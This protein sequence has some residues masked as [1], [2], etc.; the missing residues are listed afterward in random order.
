[1]FQVKRQPIAWRMPPIFDWRRRPL[2]GVRG[3][4]ATTGAPSHISIQ[5]PQAT[6]HHTSRPVQV[7]LGNPSAGC[8]TVELPANRV[9]GAT[10]DGYV[11]SHAARG[12]VVLSRP[13]RCC[14]FGAVMRRLVFI[15]WLLYCGL[16]C[17][18]QPRDMS[19][20]PGWTALVKSKALCVQNDQPISRWRGSVRAGAIHE[21][22]QS[23]LAP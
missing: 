7:N 20:R 2:L 3:L 18:S 21:H 14:R 5:T 13:W 1:M 23:Q 8:F 19:K 12:S 9:R 4:A 16:A 6:G 22:P 10:C 11:G 17:G 15:L